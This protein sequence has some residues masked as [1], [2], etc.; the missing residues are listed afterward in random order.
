[1]TSNLLTIIN[2]QKTI[3]F[4]QALFKKAVNLILEKLDIL[5]KE[6]TISFV[7]P[8][9]IRSLN[10]EYRGKDYVTD[11]LSFHIGDEMYPSMLGDIIICPHKAILQANEIGNTLEEELI[12]LALHGIL[13]LLGYDHEDPAE[14]A[15]MLG[16]QSELKDFLSQKLDLWK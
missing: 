6:V 15:I 7:T 3:F 14:E 16:K 8:A 2:N 9:R 12:F 1:M 5:D 10:N 11:V 4:E 13:H